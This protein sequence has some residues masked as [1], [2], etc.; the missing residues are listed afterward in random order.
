MGGGRL[1][2][3]RCSN[4]PVRHRVCAAGHRSPEGAHARERDRRRLDDV[5]PDLVD[6]GGGKIDFR[7]LGR[8]RTFALLSED[9]RAGV[10]C[11][12]CETNSPAPPHVGAVHFDIDLKV[13]E[14]WTL[15]EVVDLV[16]ETCLS[17]IQRSFPREPG[18]SPLE[19]KA[20]LVL[21]PVS[22]CADGSRRLRA[23]RI[24]RMLCARCDGALSVNPEAVRCECAACGLAYDVDEPFALTHRRRGRRQGGAATTRGD[25]A[26][27]GWVPVD[28]EEEEEEHEQ[29]C[30]GG[31]DGPAR[32]ARVEICTRSATSSRA[33]SSG[34]AATRR[35]SRP[36][37]APGRT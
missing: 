37:R 2:N 11:G 12:V 22:H 31:A 6:L 14:A 17:A 3:P 4:E 5:R 1:S 32:A 35:A 23:K 13:S 18:R 28:G 7:V 33:T 34:R 30:G 21:T 10:H 16:R 8:K 36:T 25:G 9:I 20:L 19:G 26:E 24:E 15:D 27:D 29:G